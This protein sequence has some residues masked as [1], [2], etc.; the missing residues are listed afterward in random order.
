M[1]FASSDDGTGIGLFVIRDVL[2]Q[3]GGRLE[4]QTRDAA[5][6]EGQGTMSTVSIP[7]KQVKRISP[8][9]DL[10]EDSE[11]LSVLVVD[12]LSDVRDSLVDVTRRLGHACRAVG[13]AAEARPL[14]ASTHFDVALIDLEMPDTDGLALATEIRESGG[15]NTSAMLILISAAENQATGQAWPFDGFLQKPIDGQ[16]LARL[17]GARCEPQSA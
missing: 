8:E 5:D 4:V 12:D 15:P 14:L 16:A 13:S 3:L 6:P 1:P 7:A 10:F 11:A 17:I 2:Q 9:D